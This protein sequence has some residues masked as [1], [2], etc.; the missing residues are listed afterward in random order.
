MV[1][2]IVVNYI[3]RKILTK[4]N[5]IELLE[6]Q[7]LYYKTSL[8]SVEYSI[9]TLSLKFFEVPEE[10]M[11][12]FFKSACHHF[13]NNSRPLIAIEL[14]FSSLDRAIRRTSICIRFISFE[15]VFHGCF[16]TDIFLLP[17]FISCHSKLGSNYT[18]I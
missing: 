2:L 10:L 13:L 15:E 3:H 17:I 18:K 5:V 8:N 12:D 7:M 16:Q 9:K 11:A 4:I 14:G 6:R 1:Y